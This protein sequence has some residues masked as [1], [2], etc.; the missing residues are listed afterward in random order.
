MCNDKCHTYFSSDPEDETTKLQ[1]RLKMDR[2]RFESAHLK[3]S[4]LV[5]RSQYSD[6]STFLVTM[7]AD[8]GDMLKSF[9]PL[10]Y[11]F[12]SE[13]YSSM[14]ILLLHNILLCCYFN[15]RAPVH[16]SRL[17]ERTGTRWEHEK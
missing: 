5:I 11:K 8:V 17:Q 9:T 1:L 13:I 12:F 4:M 7:T 10:F 2:R 15:C 16:F 6:L 3:Y 14:S